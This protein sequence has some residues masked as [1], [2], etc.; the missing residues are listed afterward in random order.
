MT[1][2]NLLLSLRE[3]IS[4]EIRHYRYDSD[5]EESKSVGVYLQLSD[6]NFIDEKKYPLVMINIQSIVDNP[7]DHVANVE[8]T[9]GTYGEDEFALMELLNITERIRQYLMKNRI[10]SSKFPM[11]YPIESQIYP[12][13]TY[14]FRFSYIKVSYVING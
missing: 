3:G 11:R 8:I 4:G 13:Q 2:V 9:I 14:P 6:E 1:P 5:D 12:D 10:I 7:I